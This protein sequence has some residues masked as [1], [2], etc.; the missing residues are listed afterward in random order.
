MKW[1][2]YFHNL[3]S[4]PQQN[5]GFSLGSTLAG[6][7][8]SMNLFVNSWTIY[9]FLIPVVDSFKSKKVLGVLRMFCMGLQFVLLSFNRC[10]VNK[11]LNVWANN[12][13]F[14]WLSVSRWLKKKEKSIA[15]SL[16]FRYFFFLILIR[17]FNTATTFIFSTCT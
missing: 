13:T 4:I 17:H 14:H 11:L 10:G 1:M 8:C 2:G 16:H 5:T 3:V 6:S 15:C 12:C 9:L 7:N